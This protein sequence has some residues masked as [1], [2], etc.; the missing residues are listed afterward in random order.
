MPGT[1]P[2]SRCTVY[3]GTTLALIVRSI[4][5]FAIPAKPEMKAAA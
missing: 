1:I 4:G 3:R 5:E 2:A